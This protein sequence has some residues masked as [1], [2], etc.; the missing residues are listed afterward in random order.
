[1]INLGALKHTSR[2]RHTTISNIMLW[3]RLSNNLPLLGHSQCK[4]EA[5]LGPAGRMRSSLLLQIKP[6]RCHRQCSHS[7][8]YQHL[9]AHFEPG[10]CALASLQVQV[11]ICNPYVARF[12]AAAS[13][14]HADL[15]LPHQPGHHRLVILA[16][17]RG[18]CTGCVLG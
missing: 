14:Q 13:G 5:R 18:E 17:Y 16:A 3:M 7:M 8:V 2:P 4:P 10:S 9:Q 12:P 15:V 6:S 1:M 11:C